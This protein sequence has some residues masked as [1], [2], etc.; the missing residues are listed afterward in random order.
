M[1]FKAVSLILTTKKMLNSDLFI[2]DANGLHIS[3]HI[4]AI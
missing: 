2:Q 1:L 3:P 4:V